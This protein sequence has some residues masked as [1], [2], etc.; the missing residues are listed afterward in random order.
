M[1]VKFHV[2]LPLALSICILGGCGTKSADT[3]SVTEPEETAAA[4]EEIATGNAIDNVLKSTMQ[5]DSGFV[6]EAFGILG[7]KSRKSRNQR[8]LR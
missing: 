1:N 6:F 3:D 4:D 8:F 5:P 7:K 2:L